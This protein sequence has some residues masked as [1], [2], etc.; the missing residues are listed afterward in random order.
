MSIDYSKW[1]SIVISDDERDTNSESDSPSSIPL[2]QPPVNTQPDPTENGT[3][4]RVAWNKSVINKALE[5]KDSPSEAAIDDE[6]DNRRMAQYFKD[7]EALIKQFAV[8]DKLDDCKEF[9]LKHP[10]LANEYAANYMTIEALNL[11]MLNKE[12]DMEKY[13]ANCMAL[14]YLL[15]FAKTCNAAATNTIVIEE[16]FKKYRSE[17]PTYMNAYKA[18]VE[19]FKD[20]LRKRAHAKRQEILQK[21]EASGRQDPA[22]ES[23]SGLDPQDVFS[24]LPEA[25]KEVF[26]SK[27]MGKL[28]DVSRSM[29]REVFEYHL[30]RCISSGLLA[31]NKSNPTTDEE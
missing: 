30:K 11:A 24:S 1:N 18:D 16:H 9:L 25:L 26:A 2:S 13:A 12:G 28:A 31:P 27:D 4:T 6:E 15:Q 20:R 14:Q 5:Q 8:L 19:A 29:D 10:A 21:Q 22:A 7:H 3:T 17:D 23:P